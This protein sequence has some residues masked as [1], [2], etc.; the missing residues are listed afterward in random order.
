[1]PLLSLVLACSS[2]PMLTSVDPGEAL[3]GA[4]I[5]ILGDGFATGAIAELARGDQMIALEGVSV[6]GAVLL[7]AR[8]PESVAEGTYDLRV[9][10]GTKEALLADALRV[11]APAGDVA[12]S[13]EFQSVTSTSLLTHF[14]DIVRQHKNGERETLRIPFDD[15][16]RLEYEATRK[17]D[18]ALCS[19][20]FLRKRDGQRVLFADDETTAWK[21][22]AY[23]LARDMGKP[24]QVTRDDSE[25]P[26]ATDA[27]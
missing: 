19:A 12:C 15:V 26:A 2:G 27:Q 4:V 23:K 24:I 16:E 22:R 8:V 18:G 7:E 14:V 10:M 21:E 6:A 20:V 13:G 5:K 25:E 3:P 17:A 9:S 1:M 11:T